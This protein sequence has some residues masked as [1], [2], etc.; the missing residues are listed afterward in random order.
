MPTLPDDVLCEIA[1][2]SSAR[3]LLRLG[4]CCRDLHAGVKQQ[5]LWKILCSSDFGARHSVADGN[6]FAAYS[7]L[8]AF[9]KNPRDIPYEEVDV[10][11]GDSTIEPV[12]DGVIYGLRIG[13]KPVQAMYTSGPYTIERVFLLSTVPL[14]RI[15]DS[16]NALQQQTFTGAI[17]P[18]APL[19]AQFT[20]VLKLL[21]N[22]KYKIG[23]FANLPFDI[24]FP[25]PKESAEAICDIHEE[26]YQF[27]NQHRLIGTQDVVSEDRVA[28]YQSLLQA[29]AHPFAVVCER[30]VVDGHH[31]LSAHSKLGTAAAVLMIAP[32]DNTEG[33]NMKDEVLVPLFAAQGR[34][35]DMYQPEDERLY[36]GF[37]RDLGAPKTEDAE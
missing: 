36:W 33:V 23:Y 8:A 7:R 34:R 28:E 29:G 15:Q 30:G 22:G 9:A 20:D 6:Y 5:N 10:T 13:G 14:D 37:A 21:K 4:A 32:V 18:D 17:D 35:L 12:S 25:V 24:Q 3:S 19:S 1:K 2:Y 27:D 16:V 31:K 11:D 26:E